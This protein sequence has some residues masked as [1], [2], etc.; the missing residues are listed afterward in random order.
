MRE[1]ERETE[2]ERERKREEEIEREGNKRQ[3][4]RVRK[5]D[6]RTRYTIHQTFAGGKARTTWNLWKCKPG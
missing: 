6:T 5:V 4:D 2:R 3:K 1:R